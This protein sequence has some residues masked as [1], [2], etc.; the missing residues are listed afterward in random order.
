LDFIV[1]ESGSGYTWFEN[2][3]ENKLTPW[4][5]DPVSDTPGEILYVMDEHA[6][7]VWSVTP[8][9]V[10]EKEP[11]MIRHGFGYTV[12]SHASHGIEQEM[13]QFVPVDDSVKISILK[14]KNQSQEI[15]A[16]SDILYK[17]G[18]WSQRSVYCHAYNTKADNGMI[19]IKNNYNDEFPGRVAFIDSSLKVNSLT[20]DRK[21]FFGAG[22]I[23]NPEGIKRTS[24]SGTTGAG[25]TLVL[26]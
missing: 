26:P 4:S 3:R 13:V 22:D 5:N 10:R 23:A 14:L 24:L 25:L 11:Y 8:L 12:F 9:P 21:E 7:D 16:E 17:A 19:V 2:S 20:C 15:G 6:G 18:P 1:T